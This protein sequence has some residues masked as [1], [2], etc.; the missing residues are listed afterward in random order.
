[1]RFT[2]VSSTANDVMPFRDNWGYLIVNARDCEFT[3]VSL[4]GWASQVITE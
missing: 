4:G 1:M 2:R 3:A